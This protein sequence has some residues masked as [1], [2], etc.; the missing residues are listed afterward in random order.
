MCRR[1]VYAAAK[2]VYEITTDFYIKSGVKV[3]LIDLDNTLDS[4]KLYHPTEKAYE[5]IKKIRD[6]GIT[7]IIVSNNKGKRVSSYANDLGV[8]YIN[9][10]MKP[11]ASRINKFVKAHGYNKDEMMLI[12]DQMVTDVGAGNHAHIRVVLTEKLVPED[13]WTT[14]INR[15]LGNRIRK[16]QAKKGKLIDWRTL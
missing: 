4:Y 2:S 11:F 16:H 10:A 9:S 1:K 7:P 15:I 8:K 5:L 14:R 13:Q 6:A 12:G 3:L